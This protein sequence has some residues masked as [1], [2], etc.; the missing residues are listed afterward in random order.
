MAAIWID[1][2]EIGR[3]FGG[4]VLVEVMAGCG[5]QLAVFSDRLGE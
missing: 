3:F 4:V 5:D 1:D 2:Q